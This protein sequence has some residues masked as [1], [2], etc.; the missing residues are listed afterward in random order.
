VGV[1]PPLAAAAG[2]AGALIEKDVR[3]LR[4][5]VVLCRGAVEDVVVHSLE[6]DDDSALPV[7]IATTALARAR[8]MI[9][10]DLQPERMV[11]LLSRQPDD[12]AAA[13]ATMGVTNVGPSRSSTSHL[14]GWCAATPPRMGPLFHHPSLPY[15]EHRARAGRAARRRQPG[16]PRRHPRQI[17]IRRAHGAS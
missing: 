13:F 15:G 5:A 11:A 16:L 2:D 9:A 8:D 12:T 1:P 10:Q 6:I 4:L 14:W 17:L 3:Q 7:A